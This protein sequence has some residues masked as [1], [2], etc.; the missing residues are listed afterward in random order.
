M[1]KT[2]DTIHRITDPA[3][4]AEWRKE[5]GDRPVHFVP[6]MGN[7]HAGHVR[8]VEAASGNDATVIASIFVNPTQFGPNED[9]AHY[10][11]TPGDDLEALARAGCD[12]VWAPSV[13]TMYPLPEPL[14]CAIRPPAALTGVLC[15]AQRPGHFEG[16]C[17]VVMR[18]F[19]QVRPDR[20]FF[21]EKD[22]Q[23]LVVIR[24]MALDFSLP[25][26]VEAVPTVRDDDGLALSSRNRYLSAEERRKAPLLYRTLREAAE[27]ASKSP[28]AEL[29]ALERTAAERLAAAGFEPEYVEF[30]DPGTL[31]PPDGPNLRLFAAARLGK[32]RLIDNVAVKRQICR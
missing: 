30:R 28:E 1:K 15:G 20:A 6:T 27:L 22:F 25:V 3:A 7:L 21:G 10:P 13:E 5:V 19:W 23:Q 9:Y 24:N 2:A 8:L 4:L 31:G 26:A 18:L 12:C 16:V 11:R 29:D 17:S 14:R 32:A